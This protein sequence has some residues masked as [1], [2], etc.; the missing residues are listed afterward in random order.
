MKDKSPGD[1]VV[2]GFGKITSRMV[3]VNAADFT[4]LGSS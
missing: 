2:S 4:T 3:G 1:G